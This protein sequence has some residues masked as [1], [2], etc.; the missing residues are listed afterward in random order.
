M[1]FATILSLSA[2]FVSVANA[3]APAPPAFCRFPQQQQT[4]CFA[5]DPEDEEEGLDLNLEEMF[6]M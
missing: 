6:D 3:F 4:K 1:K 5:S 2:L